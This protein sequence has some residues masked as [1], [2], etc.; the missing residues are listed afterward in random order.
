MSADR[1][2]PTTASD[3]PR[4]IL[5]AEDNAMNQ[6]VI[7]RQLMLLGFEADMAGDGREALL[8]WQRGQYGLLLSDLHMPYMDG[9]ELTKAIRG[10]EPAGAARLPIFALTANAMQGEA[11]RCREAGMDGYLS[12]PLQL[13]DL[14]SLLQLWLP[15]V[16]ANLPAAGNDALHASGDAPLDV[17]V[18]EELVGEDPVV[19]R[20]LLAHFQA[21]ANQI[22]GLL[23]QHCAQRQSLLV[24]E[25]AHKLGSAARAAGALELGVCCAELEVAGASGDTENLARLWLSFERELEEVNGFLDALRR[26]PDGQPGTVADGGPLADHAGTANS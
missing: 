19:I 10:I 14:K 6:K 22:A 15:T 3:R 18:L 1:V 23:G 2:A 24:G 4:R 12:K 17:R 20:E 5:V 26:A 13:G 16:S 9:F 21:S 11:R 25:Q 8:R 7:L